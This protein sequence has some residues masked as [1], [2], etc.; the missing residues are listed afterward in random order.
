MILSVI[1]EPCWVDSLT[2][3]SKTEKP[4]MFNEENTIEQMVLDTLCCGVTSNM[5]AE[6]LASYG[7]EIKGWRFVAAEELPRQHSDVLVESM[8]RDALIRLNP[9]I[10]AQPDRADEVLYRLCRHQPVGLPDQ[11]RRSSLRYCHAGQWHPCGG[12]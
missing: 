1:R 3:F 4:Y 7:G 8:V 6:E 10:K 9:E 12:W 5:V 11:G 2:D